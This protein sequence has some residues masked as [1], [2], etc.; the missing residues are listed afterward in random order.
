MKMIKI[1]LNSITKSNHLI[2]QPIQEFVQ[3]DTIPFEWSIIEKVNISSS[4]IRIE[5]NTFYECFILNSVTFSENSKL[6]SI[7]KSSFIGIS[8]SNI[9]ISPRVI[10]IEEKALSNCKKL[11]NATLSENINADQIHLKSN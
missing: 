4:H 10:Q 3:F 2:L 1:H 9:K 7:G 11:E 8:T 6:Q 5:E